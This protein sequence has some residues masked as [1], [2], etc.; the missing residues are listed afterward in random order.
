VRKQDIDGQLQRLDS[1]I[2]NLEV[3]SEHTNEHVLSYLDLALRDLRV[4]YREM[5]SAQQFAD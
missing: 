2:K 5:V 1:L 4:A 3:L